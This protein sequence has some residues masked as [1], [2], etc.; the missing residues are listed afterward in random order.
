MLVSPLVLKVVAAVV[1]V[2]A[3]A[4]S[5]ILFNFFYYN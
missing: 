2:M 1:S 5:S 3:S 4:F